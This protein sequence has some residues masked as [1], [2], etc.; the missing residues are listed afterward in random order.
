[1]PP[2]IAGARTDFDA[3]DD[4][5]LDLESGMDYL[6]PSQDG[7]AFMKMLGF[8]ENS[9]RSFKH[10]WTETALALRR[11]VITVTNVATSIP[12][13]NAAQYMVGTILA[14]EAERMRITAVSPPNVTVT[15]GALGTSAVAHTAKEMYTT[16]TA[17][18][19]NTLAG[20]GV[21][22]TAVRLFNYVQT[23]ERVV[24]IS[25]DEIMQA[26]SEGDIM[27]GQVA[28]RYIEMMREMSAAFMYGVRYEDTTNKYRTTGGIFNHFISTNQVNAAGAALSQSIIDALILQIVLAG[29]DP[30]AILLHPWQKQKLDALDNNKQLLGK[31]EHVGGGLIT[32]TWQS[33]VLDHPLDIIV[34]HTID[35]QAF[36]IL[37]P[38]EIEVKP[39]EGNGESGRIAI[40]DASQPGQDGRKKR[41][42][43]KYMVQV[44]LQ[45]GQA[46]E[47]NL[48]L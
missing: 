23:F 21:T 40:W 33:G 22:D 15:R 6:S 5:I 48:A 31:K 18:G 46:Y 43:A 42:I 11:E 37:D 34:D 25:R 38:D 39:L 44:N 27:R 28:R 47:Y 30:K 45:A 10:E 1:M 29:G 14:C 4:H 13:T 17:L 32:E 7:I 26:S 2:L 3:Q 24:E 9:V 20:T 36:G 19:Q 8:S 16:G 41:I 35:R 12:V